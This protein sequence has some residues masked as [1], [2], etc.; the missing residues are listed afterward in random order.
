MYIANVQARHPD[1]TIV[2]AH[3]G[4]PCWLDE[5]VAL[6]ASHGRTYLEVSLWQEEALAPY[7]PFL[8]MLERAV[9][10]CGADRILFASDTMYGGRLK[11]ADEWGQ[12]VRYFRDL[13]TATTG[14]ISADAVAD[15]LEHNAQ[16]AYFHRA[17]TGVRR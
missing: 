14:R 11:G 4:F 3:A 12:W 6:A 17:L 1:L 16:R 8:P 9:R 10:L 2:L 7:S 13:P 15:I 5:C